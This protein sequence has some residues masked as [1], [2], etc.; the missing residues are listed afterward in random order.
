MSAWT[1]PSAVQQQAEQRNALLPVSARLHA[2][3]PGAVAVAPEGR[4]YPAIAAL[5][6]ADEQRP[7]ELTGMTHRVT[8]GELLFISS[9]WRLLDVPEDET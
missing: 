2:A 5:R 6:T 8:V 1:Y 4:D 7:W 3:S 9:S